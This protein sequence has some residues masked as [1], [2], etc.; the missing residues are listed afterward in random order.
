MLVFRE[1]LKGAEH[2]DGAGELLCEIYRGYCCRLDHRDV[3]PIKSYA[4]GDIA[5]FTIADEAGY[6]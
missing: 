6:T 1:V 3:V 4:L 5:V 2:C